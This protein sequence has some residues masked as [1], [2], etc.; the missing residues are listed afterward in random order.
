MMYP[1]SGSD[2]DQAALSLKRFQR[3]SRNLTT[4]VII[5]AIA[6]VLLLIADIAVM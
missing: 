1:T 4:A 6:D 2:S 5:L 3:L